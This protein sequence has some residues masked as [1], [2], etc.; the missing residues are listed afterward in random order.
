MSCISLVSS[1]VVEILKCIKIIFRCSARIL[2]KLL[3]KAQIQFNFILS[4]IYI[5]IVPWVLTFLVDSDFVSGEGLGIACILH[6]YL[7]L[8]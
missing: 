6:I 2:D 1:L 5:Y 7:L 3:F 4:H 8:S